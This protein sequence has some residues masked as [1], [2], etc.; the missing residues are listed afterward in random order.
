MSFFPDAVFVLPCYID[1]ESQKE[2]FLCG[3]ETQIDDYHSFDS[4]GGKVDK[5]D[6]DVLDSA[7][8]EFNEEAFACKCLNISYPELRQLI[9]NNVI[10]TVAIDD[11][12]KKLLMYIIQLPKYQIHQILNNYSQHYYE[13]RYVPNNGFHEKDDLA[14][15]DINVFYE[16]I[17]KR[18]NLIWAKVRTLRN[19]TFT[20]RIFLRPVLKK[21]LTPLVMDSDYIKLNDD[22][23]LFFV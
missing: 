20:K 8:R 23:H 22:I 2:Y 21:L 4:F 19:E 15:I 7:T 1:Q 9:K 16:N 18:E 12:T 14:L 5:N 10:R 13:T 17:E 6:F 3:R 11:G